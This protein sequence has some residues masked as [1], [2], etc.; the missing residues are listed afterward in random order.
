[1]GD[2]V[3]VAVRCRPFNKR[4]CELGAKLCVSMNGPKTIVARSSPSAPKEKPKE[5][6]FDFSYWSFDAKDASFADNP[7]VYRDLGVG[8]LNN[9]W[10]GYNSTLFAY[11]QTG[12]GQLEKR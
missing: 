8:V 10:A 7:K 12:S 4:E 2:A 11:G 5:F 6:S 3:V 1:M 9:A